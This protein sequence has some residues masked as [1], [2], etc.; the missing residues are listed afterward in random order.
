[1]PINFELVEEVMFSAV[2][3]WAG[4][5]RVRHGNVDELRHLVLTQKNIQYCVLVPLFGKVEMPKPRLD[6]VRCQPW[7]ELGH[8]IDQ[9][10]LPNSMLMKTQ[11]LNNSPP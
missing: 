7:Y 2:K 3:T 9:T 11:K 10:Y 1:V 6:R 4:L 5:G 8:W